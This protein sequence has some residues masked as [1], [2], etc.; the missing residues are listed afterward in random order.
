MH[1]INE[2]I[3]CSEDHDG[4]VAHARYEEMKLDE[5]RTRAGRTVQSPI[6]LSYEGDEDEND[7]ARLSEFIAL[8]EAGLQVEEDDDAF[9]TQAAEAVDEAEA[10]YYKRHAS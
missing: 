6:V 4:E 9:F 1:F 3:G 7:T 8:A 5:H 2:G 10:A